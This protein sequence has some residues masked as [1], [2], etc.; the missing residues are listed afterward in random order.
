MR[1]NKSL[2]AFPNFNKAGSILPSGAKAL[3]ESFCH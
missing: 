3:L 1:Q 2:L